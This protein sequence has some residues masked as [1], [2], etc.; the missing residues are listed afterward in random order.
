MFNFSDYVIV[1]IVTTLQ[2]K[3]LKSNFKHTTTTNNG[4]SCVDVSF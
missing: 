4:I 3:K 2:N 1:Y